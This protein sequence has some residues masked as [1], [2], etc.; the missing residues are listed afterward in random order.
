VSKRKLLLADDSLTIQKVVNL[1]FA[2][3]GIDVEIAKDG[4]EAID[5]INA[6][7]PDIIL[8]DIHMP[9]TDGYKLCEMIRGSDQTKDIPV[10]LL[11]GSFEPFDANEAARVGASS[12]LT[13]PFSSIRAL[14]DKV[15][16]L[17]DKAAST[18]DSIHETYAQAPESEPVSASDAE[19]E[20]L[21]EQPFDAP[22][23]DDEPD[24]IESL[25]HQSLSGGEPD[26]PETIEYIDAGMDDEMVEAEHFGGYE[27]VETAAETEPE[28][29]NEAGEVSDETPYEE[30]AYQ[31]ATG[32]EVVSQES[33][34]EDAPA[35]E[36]T[37]EVPSTG[38]ETTQLTEPEYSP[39]GHV[40]QEFETFDEF[41][42]DGGIHDSEAADIAEFESSMSDYRERN[43][44]AWESSR[45]ETPGEETENTYHEQPAEQY[46]EATNEYEQP[47]ENYTEQT[48]SDAETTEEFVT[49]P[50]EDP[51]EFE[52][53]Q[54]LELPNTGGVNLVTSSE[55]ISQ[56][57]LQ[58]AVSLSP[59]LIEMIVE[60]VV[61]R[62]RRES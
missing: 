49:H 18:D 27:N 20:P 14:V 28:T 39:H 7:L 52:E 16:E 34:S 12:V 1:T 54:L 6:G 51:F 40:T 36:E 59:E 45:E 48:G 55:A 26:E 32:F 24:D 2:D 57:S 17:L 44:E 62:L 37:A 5:R 10:V 29:S 22:A 58:R 25:Y 19:T 41:K 60:R 15:N 35:Y 47:T 8:A 23:S 43:R 61:E 33:P 53:V 46:A 38:Y 13:K 3:E 21:P 31:E 9:G 11:V 4:N 50:V 42:E 30:P 56:E